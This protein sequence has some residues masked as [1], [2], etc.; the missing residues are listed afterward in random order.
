MVA[1]GM[2]IAGVISYEAQRA[3]VLDQVDTALRDQFDLARRV[4]E[5][6]SATSVR[7]ALTRVLSLTS[8]PSEGGTVGIVD[9]RATFLPPVHEALRPDR[10]PGFVARASEG[11]GARLDT[12]R[13]GG[14]WIRYVSVP[15]HVQGDS[16]T[17]SYV[18]AVDVDARLRGVDR[19][20]LLY[21]IV[22]AAVLLV[23]G[24][25]G[26]FVAG[27]L[28][29]PVRHLREAAE[30]ITLTDLDER[31]PVDGHDDVSRLTATV[32]GML[33]RIRDGIAQQRRL[34]DDVR[35]D[36][37][38]PLTVVRGH[39]ELIDEN[40]PDDV[41]S[42][43]TIATEEVDRMTRLVDELSRIAEFGLPAAE[44]EPTDTR[45]LAA[46]MLERVRGIAG[47]DWRTSR[48][49]AAEV[50]IDRDRIVEAWLQLAQ[51]AATYAPAGSP[52]ELAVLADDDEIRLEVRD[53]GPGVPPE[54]R[55][56]IFERG[57]R[58]SA[59][60]GRPGTG[61]GLTIVAAIARAHGGRVEVGDAPD[62]GAVF[63]IVLPRRASEDRR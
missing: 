19:S 53:R 29:A 28:L 32:N 41:R 22:S 37:R 51:N 47:H 49:D 62:G 5:D 45:R 7:D 10:L 42:A 59:A 44:P 33:D 40:D 11:G 27:R 6:G 25:L 57:E 61:V 63:G 46:G 9:G 20:A 23:A 35:H 24:V 14:R 8:A 15:V 38:A 31:I 21:A 12:F 18:A 48:V 1:V 58:G 17:G 36:L 13:G 4:V 39:L 34:L 54:E 2:T 56:R 16:A 55:A 52:I 43:R 26:W 3:F 50:T 30:R 60:D